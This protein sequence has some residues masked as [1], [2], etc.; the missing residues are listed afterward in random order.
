MHVEEGAKKQSYEY[1][2]E[3]CEK[4]LTYACSSSFERH[5]RQ[6]KR[7]IAFQTYQCEHC[8]FTYLYPYA[9][10][11]H[12][13]KSHHGGS[14]V[15]PDGICTKPKL[16]KPVEADT[17]QLYPCKICNKTLSYSKYSYFW[18][19]MQTHLSSNVYVCAHCESKCSSP[20]GLSSHCMYTHHGGI[21]Q[22]PEGICK[23]P[24]IRSTSAPE[25]YKG[26][27]RINTRNYC[28][29]ILIGRRHFVLG[30][31]S[32]AFYSARLYDEAMHAIT[33]ETTE[34]NFPG[35]HVDCKCQERRETYEDLCQLYESTLVDSF[36]SDN[37]NGCPP[38]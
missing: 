38:C 29:R 3:T 13:Q 6:H 25:C 31:Y 12:C 4:T 21:S 15:C 26:V 35:E 28:A 8:P 11:R 19:H 20:A 27:Q 23:V 9:L 7:T 2:C 32:S 16:S 33:R 22:C 30:T 5:K 18:R 14:T 17:K 36:I 1:F 24:E 37:A 10:K 34:L